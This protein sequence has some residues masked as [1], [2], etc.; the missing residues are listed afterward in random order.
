M[1]TTHI[2][3]MYTPPPPPPPP[4]ASI[5]LLAVHNCIRSLTDQDC[6]PNNFCSI[7]CMHYIGDAAV[8]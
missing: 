8:V 4:L 7:T 2:W 5:G 1:Q 3:D 6:T